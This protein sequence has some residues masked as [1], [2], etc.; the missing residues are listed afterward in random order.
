VIFNLRTLH[1][2]GGIATTRH[3]FRRLHDAAIAEGG[4]FFLTYHRYA[5]REQL[6]AC[7]PMFERFLH[8]KRTYDPTGRL[9]SD[10]Y[11]HHQAMFRNAVGPPA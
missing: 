2:P 10:W 5:T 8:L 11:R 4:S 3:T 6:E 1:T 7:Y 9:A